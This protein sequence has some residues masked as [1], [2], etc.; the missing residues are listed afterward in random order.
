MAV[1]FA[2][3]GCGAI[4]RKHAEALS[5]HVDGAELVAFC[6]HQ[7]GKAQVFADQYGVRAFGDLAEMI[8]DIGGSIDVVAVLTPTG[9]HCENAIE[10]AGY[11][12]H[13]VVEKPMALGV[14]SAQRMLNAC[15][16]AGVELFVVKQNRFNRPVQHLRRAL[17]QGRFGELVM[18]T[19]RVRWCR[20]EAYYG[21]D[22]W[23]G[24]TS[25][26]GGV[27]ENQAS[28]HLDL[29]QWI[30]GPVQS[31][32]CAKTRRLASIEAEDT[33]I[34]TLTFESGALGV[35]EATTATRPRDLEGSIS[36]LGT[37]GSVEI[38]GFAANKIKIWEFV[39][40]RSEDDDIRTIY[41]SN[42]DGEPLYAH[43]QYLQQVVN[44]LMQ[45][46]ASPVSGEE[47]IKTV[48]L[49]EAMRLSHESRV[50]TDLGALSRTR[51]NAERSPD[52]VGAFG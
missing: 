30:G 21:R 13:V 43:T 2:L 28:H 26:D 39:E 19:A 32:S 31:V 25:L 41:G 7:K 18:V 4:A 15:S 33:A 48:Q 50:P 22:A 51:P 45:K 44:K 35:I 23:R 17:D 37:G 40:P 10:V 11:G 49:L 52:M 16:A 9:F 47:G 29:I 12:K 14:L 6:D 24:T 5:K 38:G 8:G 20:D 3:L 34:A 1:R 42:P 36:V 27:L 46:E